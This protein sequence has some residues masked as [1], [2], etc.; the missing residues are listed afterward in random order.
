MFSISNHFFFHSNL[1]TCPVGT[2]PLTDAIQNLKDSIENTATPA[3]IVAA[4]KKLLKFLKTLASDCILVVNDPDQTCPP[5]QTA[6]SKSDLEKAGL[7]LT[8]CTYFFITCPVGSY[9]LAQAIKDT[10][11]AVKDSTDADIKAAL[12]IVLRILKKL[13]N[14]C[15]AIVEGSEATCITGFTAV[16]N[17]K[18]A[19]I[20]VTLCVY[21]VETLS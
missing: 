9:N 5:G 21:D 11:Q 18:L 3:E 14:D 4:L 1:A 13:T 19:K 7:S 6:I 8:I 15:V 12:K 20:G 16:V 10:E 2:L 17:S